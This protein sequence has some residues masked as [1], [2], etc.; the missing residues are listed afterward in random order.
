MIVGGYSLDLYCSNEEV[1]RWQVQEDYYASFGGHN[2]KQAYKDARL[3]GWVI[4]DRKNGICY[5][6][7]CKQKRTK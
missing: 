3:A 1:H 5:C 7:K 4:R 6:P 2:A